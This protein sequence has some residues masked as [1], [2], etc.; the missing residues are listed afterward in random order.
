MEI[1]IQ[2]N[3]HTIINESTIRWIKQMNE[4][5]YI[6]TKSEGCITYLDTHSVCKNIKPILYNKLK[7]K[8]TEKE[9]E[10]IRFRLI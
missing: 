10:F 8:F 1:F 6:C 5:M 3:E 7:Q 4:C 9:T 2:V